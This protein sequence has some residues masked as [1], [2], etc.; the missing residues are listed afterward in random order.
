MSVKYVV[1]TTE[2]ELRYQDIILF[3][4]L[5]ETAIIKANTSPDILL[6]RAYRSY[7]FFSFTIFFHI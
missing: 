5:W 1:E 3:N 6:S 7:D 4:S 2:L